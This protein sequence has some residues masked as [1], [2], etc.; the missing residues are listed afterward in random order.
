MKR[1]SLAR[2]KALRDAAMEDRVK[3][4]HPKNCAPAVTPEMIE[5]AKAAGR[6]TRVP[7]KRRGR[8]Y[9]Q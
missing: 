4:R 9:A 3:P 6:F 5:E 7:S 1:T 2:L 8:P